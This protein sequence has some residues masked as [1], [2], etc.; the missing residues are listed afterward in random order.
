[1]KK[2]IFLLIFFISCISYV[3]A[4]YYPPPYQPLKIPGGSP[5]EGYITITD[6]VYSNTFNIQSLPVGEDPTYGKVRYIRLKLQCN[7]RFNK[8]WYH[9]WPLTNTTY[10][11]FFFGRF[12]ELTLLKSDFNNTSIEGWGDY[13]VGYQFEIRY[14]YNA[15]G[16]A[17]LEVRLMQ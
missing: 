6:N 3:D 16:S 5:P 14:P 15:V 13:C 1:M 4:Q 8:I 7:G 17:A 12:P 11:S 9:L 2:S 10:N